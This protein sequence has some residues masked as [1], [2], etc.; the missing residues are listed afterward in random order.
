MV[1]DLRGLGADAFA[2]SIELC[3]YGRSTSFMFLPGAACAQLARNLRLQ[4]SRVRSDTAAYCAGHT[5]SSTS[6]SVSGILPRSIEG[7]AF[8]LTR[9]GWRRSHQEGG[10][11]LR[12]YL[13]SD[14]E[15]ACYRQ[16]LPTVLFFPFEA[17]AAP[18]HSAHGCYRT[19]QSVPSPN[20]MKNFMTM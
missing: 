17:S 8:L 1:C 11:R 6:L 2:L 13:G 15:R 14:S 9:A 5:G 20:M 16:H 7:S 18:Y 10:Q 4:P 12:L 19:V 3:V